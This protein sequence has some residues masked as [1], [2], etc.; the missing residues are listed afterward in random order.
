MLII[1]CQVQFCINTKDPL[2]RHRQY[3]AAKGCQGGWTGPGIS[4]RVKQGNVCGCVSVALTL[5]KPWLFSSKTCIV[6]TGI[7]HSLNYEP[8]NRAVAK[9]STQSLSWCACSQNHKEGFLC[10]YAKCQEATILSS[11]WLIRGKT[12]PPLGPPPIP[13]T[14]IHSTLL[15]M[16]TLF[17]VRWEVEFF[18]SLDGGIECSGSFV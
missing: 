9:D 17:L 8:T 16:L 15:Y 4:K 2:L 18:L 6:L 12:V 13:S 11:T 5:I 7:S 10:C 14:V 1:R 3:T